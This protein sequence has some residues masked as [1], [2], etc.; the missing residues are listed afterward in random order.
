MIGKP[1]VI[2]ADEPVGTLHT[3][4]GRMIM[5]LLARLNRDGTT[6]IQVTHSA[7][8]AAYGS[9]IIRLKDGWLDGEPHSSSASR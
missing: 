1:K 4:H 8:W 5:E 3:D 6:V 9:R 7:E 2:L